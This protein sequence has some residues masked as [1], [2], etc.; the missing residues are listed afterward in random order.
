MREV[1][2]CSPNQLVM[3]EDVPVS[4]TQFYDFED[5]LSYL[6][7]EGIGNSILVVLDASYGSSVWFHDYEILQRTFPNVEVSVVYATD[8][9]PDEVWQSILKVVQSKPL[10]KAVESTPKKNLSEEIKFNKSE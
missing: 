7:S 1:L 10:S 3:R 8:F 9:N 5:M 2:W 6:G 4:L